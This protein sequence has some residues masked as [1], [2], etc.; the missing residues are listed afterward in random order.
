MAKELENER[1]QT[2]NQWGEERL[3]FDEYYIVIPFGERSGV[4]ETELITESQF[5]ELCRE[6]GV[7][8]PKY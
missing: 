8:S 1:V 4:K 7:Y 5:L 6:S 2:L 3:K